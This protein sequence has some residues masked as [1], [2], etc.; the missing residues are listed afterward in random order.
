[1]MNDS[2]RSVWDILLRGRPT[3]DRLT[4]KEVHTELTDKMYYAVDSGGQRHLLILLNAEGEGLTD[5]Q[6]R[7]FSV[8]T[9][10]LNVLNNE[11]QK[12]IDITCND[13][14]GHPAFDLLAEEIASNLG[15][16][17]LSPSISTSVVLEKWRRFWSKLTRQHLSRAEQIGLFAELWF[18]SEW[19]I[20]KKG[21]ES[22]HSWQG[23]FGHRND[24]ENDLYCIEVKA[25]TS[26][27]GRIFRVNGIDQLDHPENGTF[28]F[29][30]VRL[31]ETENQGKSLP[32]LVSDIMKNL[33]DQ[34]KALNHLEEGL[35]LAGY[36]DTHAELY[37]RIKFRVREACLFEV[38]EDFPKLDKNLIQIPP[39]VE[40]IEYEINLNTF[41]HL[42]VASSPAEW[43]L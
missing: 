33:V 12:Y 40:R 31:T 18:L 32:M 11:P 34:H 38:K 39:G 22:M 5:T 9:R 16:K 28:Y 19:L 2:I 1:M 30:G 43:T 21:V 26:G 37:E 10:H 35:A 13:S 14:E 36:S 3:L 29:F 7:G 24:F 41:D 27:R 42:I 17:N 15:D 20:P 4:A 25:T 8:T 6:S 23:P